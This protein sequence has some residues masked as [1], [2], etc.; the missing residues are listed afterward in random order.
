MNFKIFIEKWV[1]PTILWRHRTSS[2]GLIFFIRFLK[3]KKN[4]RKKSFSNCESGPSEQKM[5]WKK[6]AGCSYPWSIREGAGGFSS[7]LRGSCPNN[8]GRFLKIVQDEHRMATWGNSPR[9]PK[10]LMLL[11]LSLSP[12]ISHY[13]LM[14]RTLKTQDHTY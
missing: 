2:N 11:T 13:L 12:F 7:R 14:I 4:L 1:L 10:Q 9:M 5:V 6:K 3:K 8:T